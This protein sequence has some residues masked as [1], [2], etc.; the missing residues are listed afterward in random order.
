MPKPTIGVLGLGVFGR[1]I[2]NTLSKFD[3]DIIAVRV[4]TLMKMPLTTLNLC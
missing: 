4:R 1:S 3:C 2:V